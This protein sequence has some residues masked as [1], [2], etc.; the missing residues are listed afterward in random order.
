MGDRRPSR[1][2]RCDLVE[3]KP[4][5]DILLT[6][7]ADGA[8]D[9]LPLMPEMTE[10]CGRERPLFGRDARLRKVDEAASLPTKIDPQR[11]ERLRA[12]LKVKTGPATYFCQT[13]E[14]PKAALPLARP[15]RLRRYL[16]GLFAGNYTPLQMER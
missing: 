14:L 11:F 5:D 10:F 9:H 12:R 16:G 4:P 8:I 1:L 13:S 6:L 7:D 3:V 2:R 15:Q